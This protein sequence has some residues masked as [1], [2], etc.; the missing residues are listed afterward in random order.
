MN[1]N[2]KPHSAR[3]NGARRAIWHP[4]IDFLLMGLMLVLICCGYLVF[5]VPGVV[6]MANNWSLHLLFAFNLLVIGINIHHY[7]MDGEIWKASNID[8]QRTLFAHLGER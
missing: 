7:F 1:N 4:V 3:V 2:I 6:I 8:M 5:I